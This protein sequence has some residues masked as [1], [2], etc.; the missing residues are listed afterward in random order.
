MIM[1]KSYAF[2]L[3]SALLSF[4]SGCG[5]DDETKPIEQTPPKDPVA[6]TAEKIGSPMWEVVDPHQVSAPWGPDATN[7]DGVV[8]L[9][10]KIL[11]TPNHVWIDS[12][13]IGPGA[14]HAGPYDSEMSE[15][16][17]ALGYKDGAKF[18]QSEVMIPNGVF[19][20]MMVV[21]SDGSP[22]G[23]SPDST[24]GPII[25]HTVFPISVEYS[26]YDGEVAD[27]DLTGGFFVPALDKI[28]PPIMVDGHSHFP[29]FFSA[30]LQE[31]NVL[32]NHSWKIKMTD[33]NGDGWSVTTAFVVE[34]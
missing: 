5:G 9:A 10:K 28:D 7:Y 3:G 19:E 23:S 13:G 16:V 14:A 30:N 2:I 6:F 12:L 21:A 20:Y 29:L 25:P 4:A 17:T 33:L 32:G 34:K 31:P 18:K 24:S 26:F 27:P 15:T 22:M 8:E 1:H 11:P